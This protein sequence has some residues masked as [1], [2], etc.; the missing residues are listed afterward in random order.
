MCS[1][2]C[3][4]QTAA[5][6]HCTTAAPECGSAA[7][8]NCST[9]EPQHSSPYS[10]PMLSAL[11]P[12]RFSR[13]R[14]DSYVSCKWVKGEGVEQDPNADFGVQNGESEKTDMEIGWSGDEGISQHNKLK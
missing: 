10:N 1:A 12:M 9:A 13:M 3:V 14:Q 5:R 8:D 11:C 4:F 2:L 7:L 6:Q